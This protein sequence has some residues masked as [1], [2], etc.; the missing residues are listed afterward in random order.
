MRKSFIK[1]M[2]AA[3]IAAVMVAGCINIPVLAEEAEQAGARSGNSVFEAV[4]YSSADVGSSV[5]ANEL[6]ADFT[7]I[8]G[9]F[10]AGS[11]LVYKNIDFGSGEYK[12][13]MVLV[14]ALDDQKDKKIEVHIDS[15]VGPLISTVTVAP[16][17]DTKVFREMYGEVAATE[18]VHDVY[19][20]FP[21]QTSLNLD[22][23]TF[24]SYNG[25][26]TVEEKAERMKWWT[27]ARFGQFIHFGSYAHLAGE[28][29]P[30]SGQQAPGLSEWIM[31]G[32]KISKEEYR[33]I[34]AEEFNP[35][36]FNAKE[37]V[38]LA[39]AAGQKYIVFT[40]RHHEGV[41][42]WD[43][44]VRDFKDYSLF[45]VSNHGNYTGVD[46]IL[47]L[48]K[49]CKKQG[50]KFGAYL[51]V[52]DWHDK[53]QDNYSKTIHDEM[54]PDFVYR[55]KSQ[56]RELVETYGIELLWMDGQWE[57]WWSNDSVETKALYEYIRTLKA[58]I[59]TNNRVGGGRGDYGTPE[60]NIP[61]TGLA[62]YWES[63]LTM[64]GHWGYN[65][66]KN[67]YKDANGVVDMVVQCA[68]GG[69]NALLNL[70]PMGDGSLTEQEK[71]ALTGAGEWMDKC[72]ESIYGTKANVLTGL[73]KG[74]RGTVKEGKYY[75]HVSEILNTDIQIPSLKNE[76][77]GMKVLG[78][79]EQVSYEKVGNKTLI[80]LSEVTQDPYDTVIEISVVGMPEPQ[81]AVNYALQATNA[82]ASTYFN[83]DPT[84]AP[85]KA[86]DGDSSTRWA[87]N[88]NITSAYLEFTFDQPITLNK[89][90]ISQYYN[91]KTNYINAFTIDYWNGSDW[92]TAYTGGKVTDF[93]T[94]SFPSFTS[95]KV[96]LNLTDAS[97]PTIW[98]FGLYFEELNQLAITSPVQQPQ[99][100]NTNE[101][102]TMIGKPPFTVSG[103]WESTLPDK[104]KS[105]QIRPFQDGVDL[106]N[107]T[108]DV[109]PDGTWEVT[110]DQTFGK[111][112]VSFTAYLLDQEGNILSL[113]D[114][115][116]AI[117]RGETDLALNKPVSTSTSFTNFGGDKAVDGKTG[118]RWAPKD[119]DPNPTMT[120]DFGAPTSFNQ[121]IIREMFDRW[122]ASIDYRTTHYKIEYLDGTEWK[123]LKEED[124]L[125]GENLVINLAESVISNQLRLTL[126]GTSVGE[127]TYAPGIETFEVYNIGS[128]EIISEIAITSPAEIEKT[129]STNAGVTVIGESPFTV[130]GTWG[131][132]AP[133]KAKTVVVD[134]VQDNA[135]VETF[136]GTV[137]PDCSWE[138]V[139]DKPLG[140]G[141][142]SFT[143]SL[144]DQDGTAL[145]VSNSVTAIYRGEKD[146]ALNK[147]VT[148]STNYNNLA[149]D[150]A[151]DGMTGTRWAPHDSDLNPTMTVDFGE[152]TTFNQIIIREMFD[153]WNSTID[154]R[155]A[156]YLLEYY[157]GSEWKTIRD[158]DGAIGE[159]LVIDLTQAVTGS[160]IRL[161]LTGVGIG[162]KTYAP[163]IE[164]FEVYNISGSVE[165]VDSDKTILNK[166]ID[167]ATELQNGEE[168]NGAIQM[169]RDSFDAALTYAESVRD[170]VAATQDE[171]DAAWIALMTEI[172]K[173]GIQMGDKTLLMQVVSATADYKAED[174]AKGW[175]EFEAAMQKAQKIDENSVQSEVD[176]ALDTLLEAMAGLRY[177]ADKSLLNRVIAQAEAIDLAG[178]TPESVAQFNAALADAKAKQENTYLSVDEQP[179]V[180][181]TVSNLQMAIV[182]L[183]KAGQ[184]ATTDI[185]GDA[186]MT[187]GSASAKTGDST[188][189][190]AAAIIVL[191]AG[192]ACFT[193]RKKKNR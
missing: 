34:A 84:Y 177:R 44:K 77:L 87:T 180:D 37:I 140:K 1:Q 129:G 42:M 82:T 100:S 160:Q 14:S 9:E 128:E 58:D 80:H 36:N 163:S 167:K 20:V 70:G 110:V 146:L 103:T 86:V 18:G 190:A 63:C 188:P 102:F 178:Y 121:I 169:V 191:L 164:T 179:L 24:S 147:P 56:I 126:I 132:T 148:V 142:V 69:G 144:K 35:V 26:E 64:T 8:G 193:N 117:Y 124:G 152:P 47:E 104:V 165:P 49:E 149:G 162:S 101:V 115:V 137:K 30:G 32:A 3:A 76:I 153:R 106:K 43:T 131:S 29:P 66:F 138:V 122:N 108:A 97:R 13:L 65:K 21:E 168:Y 50:I 45:S 40:S 4:D 68:T 10:A 99:A 6:A 31:S 172:H 127:K 23:F 59:I 89:A 81:P 107:F 130:S 94:F 116:T 11:S 141:D 120:V 38:D 91:A 72:G 109:N 12:R 33:E 16:S 150:K 7:S 27:E 192:A 15:A 48:S 75:L 155:T 60:Q 93:G 92:T 181:K 113:S 174:Y 112:N 151:V 154:Y 176:E 78:T 79:G 19:F 143:A 85:S 52:M 2:L 166:V 67:S 159:N 57:P 73:P 185:Q 5:S 111:G 55:L 22:W 118:T 54:K 189:V 119:N 133:D 96:R 125:I 46:P 186:Q 39:K 28:Y 183:K 170:N 71:T 25:T 136:T 98:E 123:T 139:V 134:A 74:V 175:A 61:E 157:N 158:V 62:G 145:A 171:V 51:T 135:V 173:L 83:N 182:G 184:T 95:D 105:V 90:T 187:T 41:S 156:H 114:S 53:S 161:T 88:N 17:N